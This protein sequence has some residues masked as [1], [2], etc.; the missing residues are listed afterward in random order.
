MR[1]RRGRPVA[2]LYGAAGSLVAHAFVVLGVL[3][4]GEP[5]QPA[6]TGQPEVTW[7]A[8]S[9]SSIEEPPPEIDPADRSDP[10]PSGET[11]IP[12][13]RPWDAPEGE[14]ESSVS[15][16]T[17]PR[18]GDARQPR[19]PSADQGISGGAPVEH[20]FR[21]DRGD[22]R[23]RLSDGA[24][25]SQ[26]SRLRTPRAP[27]S[28]Q[29]LRR[30]RVVGIGDSVRRVARAQAPAPS[31][32]RSEAPPAMGGEPGGAAPS[33]QPA[34]RPEPTVAAERVAASPVAAALAGP[35][36]AELGARS[37]DEQRRGRA[38]DDRTLRA[39]SNELS[40]G[41]TD[42]SRPAAPAAT[43]SPEG[44]G[45]GIAPGAIARPS[46]GLAPT[47]PGARHPDLLA[48]ETA[49]R[50]L[51]RRYDRYKKEIEQRVNRI[52]EFPKALAL[53]LEQGET[54]VKF[55]VG[56]DGRLG[57]GPEVVKSSGFEEFDS[58]A[59]RAVRR[60]APFP[61]MPDP[62]RARPL[63]VSLRVTFDNPVIR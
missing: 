29:A 40:P 11:P 12:T 22:L 44:R 48:S 32:P 33:D 26:P 18:E 35:L 34:A 62:G 4:V 15:R 52:R 38:A 9:V 2:W 8:I 31:P 47:A 30:E 36:D 60:A 51:E 23:A 28:P 3:A 42:F 63:P 55:V 25:L 19:D 59:M 27:A 43:A 10:P 53:R 6:S 24:Q 49:E 50:A 16:T 21:R 45:P 54:I 13:P 1:N 39:A 37:F 41:L 5:P 58:A 56:T 14:R 61:P 20:A 17:G 46:A 57:G 7:S